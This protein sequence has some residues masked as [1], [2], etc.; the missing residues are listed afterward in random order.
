[1][2]S[3]PLTSAARRAWQPTGPSWRRCL[4]TTGAPVFHAFMHT[5]LH[6]STHHSLT[7]SP[8]HSPT[9]SL[10]HSLTHSLTRPLAR[11]INYPLTY[12]CSKPNQGAASKAWKAPSWFPAT[13]VP[14][15]LTRRAWSTLHVMTLDQSKGL[16][17]AFDQ[18]ADANGYISWLK[19]MQ[20][21]KDLKLEYEQVCADVP[22]LCVTYLLCCTYVRHV[23]SVCISGR[24]GEV[25]GVSCTSRPGHDAHGARAWFPS[26]QLLCC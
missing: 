22:V 7:H 14:D 10:T 13:T 25:M 19:C 6:S 9:P 2:C 15:I 26:L 16:K 21:A 3:A 4:L 8:T 1:M 17:E 5:C 20:I 12:E 24:A 18:A 23:Y 11:S